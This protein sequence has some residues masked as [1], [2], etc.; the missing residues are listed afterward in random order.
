MP[1]ETPLRLREQFPAVSTS[2]WDA[3]IRA[4][5]RGADYA[6]KLLWQP[7]DGVTVK[8][9]Y[10]SE[11][12]AGLDTQL[13][14]A[15]GTFPF[16]RGSGV[17]WAIEETF[18]PPADAI[19]ADEWHDQGATSV[20]EIAWAVAAGVDRV[21]A[22]TS[23][24]TSVDEAASSMTFVFAVGSL[25]FLEIAKLRA[26]RL[27]WAQAAGAFGPADPASARARL[28]VR[29]ARINKSLYDP[30]TNL[31]RATTEALSA[32]IGGCDRL[33][34]EAFGFDEHLA[35]NVQRILK[36]ESLIDAVADP[37]GGSYYVEV[38]TDALAR[39]ALDRV[40]AGRG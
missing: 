39:A 22:R 25:Y 38:L 6:R 33:T 11:D 5:L 31:L 35:L 20:Q 9:Y 36:D 29:T 2:E 15:P 30:Y 19:R 4:D 17:P 16:V 24:G 14:A 8:P 10:R 37:A 13:H 23:A 26:A 7:E 32:A 18:A 40:P 34:V 3:L 1:E 28:H 27:A 21:A 12:L